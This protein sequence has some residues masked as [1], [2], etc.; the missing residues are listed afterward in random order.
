[1]HPKHAGEVGD[2]LG[3]QSSSLQEE[4][5]WLEDFDGDDIGDDDENDDD[6]GETSD[7]LKV[8]LGKML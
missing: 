6:E 5:D 8:S 4:N 3:M 2:R 1:M 7:F